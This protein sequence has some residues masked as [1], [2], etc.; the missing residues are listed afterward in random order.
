MDPR[1]GSRFRRRTTANAAG[2]CGITEAI[3]QDLTGAARRHP[4]APCM[5]PEG[6]PS[7]SSREPRLIRPVTTQGH[8]EDAS[9]A[10]NHAETAAARARRQC[11]RKPLHARSGWDDPFA[12]WSARSPLP[13]KTA[14]DA[15][16]VDMHAEASSEKK[17][18]GDGFSSMAGQHRGRSP[19]PVPTADHQV[20]KRGTAYDRCRHDRQLRFLHRMAT[21]ETGGAVPA[22]ITGASSSRR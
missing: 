20:L 10:A 14:A 12:R 1:L 9:A 8:A 11:A 13:V 18:Q 21:E 7:S 3:Y 4:S 17:P 6:K 15:I 16:I 2:G 22:P 5:G 19:H